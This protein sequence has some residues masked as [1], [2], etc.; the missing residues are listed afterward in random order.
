MELKW[1]LRTVA[2]SL[3]VE[4]WFERTGDVLGMRRWSWFGRGGRNGLLTLHRT[5]Q[6]GLGILF[7][8]SGTTALRFQDCPSRTPVHTKGT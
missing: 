6:C 3:D 8:A 2:R 7:Q 5:A 1:T 4:N